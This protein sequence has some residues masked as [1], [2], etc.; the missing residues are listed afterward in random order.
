M[1]ARI[2]EGSII[3]T[4]AYMSPEQA[5]GKKV[6]ARSDIFS[7]GSVLYEMVTGRR[8]FEGGTKM[9]ILAAILNREPGRPG[10]AVV[11]PRDLERIIERCLR[12][13]VARRFQGMADL[14]VSLE[15][16]QEDAPASGALPASQPFRRWAMVAAV[17]A[18][19]LLGIGIGWRAGH[20]S[21][22]LPTRGPVLTRL[23]SDS[24]LTTDPVLF[25]RGNCWP[26]P[27]IAAERATWTS[28]CSN[29]AAERPSA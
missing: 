15:D 8:A 16:V 29:W 22:L 6:D 1:Q 23:T 19:L 26:T 7:F 11:V 9:S 2:E 14:K 25:G 20:T 18:G 27:P 28:G 24:G 4:V 10:E 17:F 3:G 5:E 12:K 13:E 21:A